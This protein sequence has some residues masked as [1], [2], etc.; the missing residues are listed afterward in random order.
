MIGIDIS[1][2]S[3]QTDKKA[4]DSYID[5]RQFLAPT[6]AEPQ[7]VPAMAHRL[8]VCRSGGKLKIPAKLLAQ[9]AR[10]SCAMRIARQYVFI[11]GETQ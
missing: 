8:V 2:L 10:Q 6:F 5:C 4:F 11:K 7:K 9:G 1:I 3:C